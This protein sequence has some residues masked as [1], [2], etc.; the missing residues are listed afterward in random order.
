MKKLKIACP[1]SEEIERLLLSETTEEVLEF[2]AAHLDSC[3]TCRRHAE[4]LGPQ[5]SLESDLHWAT[6]VRE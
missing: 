5:A 4:S 1:S 2:L 3:E 6:E